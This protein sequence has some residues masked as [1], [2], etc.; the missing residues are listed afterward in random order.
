MKAKLL[1]ASALAMTFVACTNEEIDK[2]AVAD[3]VQP[4]SFNTILGPS[5]PDTRGAVFT[6]DDL[7]QATNGFTVVAYNQGEQS[8]FTT[9]LSS[10][11]GGKAANELPSPANFMAN[12]TV[13]WSTNKWE[14]TPVKYWPGKVDGTSYGK[15]SFFALGGLASASNALAF[16]STKKTPEFNSYT[17]P[18]AAGDQKDL[19]A[20]VLF[21]EDF[22]SNSGNV[23]FAFSHILSKI[24]FTAKLAAQYS[25]AEVKITALQ[26]NY[27]NNRVA[28][29]G[30]Y[31]FAL[32]GTDHAVGVWTP[33]ATYLTGNSGD[34][35]VGS[36]D[37]TLDNSATPTVTTLNDASKFLMLIP[38]TTTMAGSLI[39][40]LTYTVTTGAETVT[41]PIT[42][43]IPAVTYEI[44]KQY[45]YNFVLTLNPVVFDVALDI[46][47]WTDGTQ[48]GDINL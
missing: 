31:A 7:Q 47:A 1:V 4:L 6:K 12:Q 15:V 11:E 25:G 32:S 26:V 17:V 38:Q 13:A 30:T 9:Y 29:T 20:D 8:A 27:G 23:K 41:Y 35:R 34:L 18:A 10:T 16:N 28:D 40:K 46:N 39:V 14:Y 2:P 3:S 19:V 21:D 48:P 36:A 22:T 45:T 37:V 5:A 44:G 24:G 43:Q 33:A 42:Y